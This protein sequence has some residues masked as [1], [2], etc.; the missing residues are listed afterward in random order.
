MSGTRFLRSNKASRGLDVVATRDTQNSSRS[1]R[2]K[3][4]I[5]TFQE[6]RQIDAWKGGATPARRPHKKELVLFPEVESSIAT[7]MN[8]GR[9]WLHYR[10]Q[11]TATQ[12]LEVGCHYS[13]APMATPMPLSLP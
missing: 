3:L 13:E 10:S 7:D 9:L 6:F 8:V 1:G 12:C 2:D 11:H 4:H 5:H